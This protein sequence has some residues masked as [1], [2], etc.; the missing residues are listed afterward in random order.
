[1]KVNKRNRITYA[2][3]IVI[4]ILLGL[5][6]RHYQNIMPKW[7]GNYAGDVLWALM[8]FLG[9]GFL[10]RAWSTLRV[11]TIAIIF[12]FCIE[13]SQ[14][15]HSPWIDAIRRTRIGALVLGFGFIWSDLFCYIIGIVFGVLIERLY[16]SIKGSTFF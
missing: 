3:A 8:V 5:A 11:A 14:L 7:I 13:I 2:I 16:K 10:F 4:T 9:M 12:S 6:S 15:Y 1:M